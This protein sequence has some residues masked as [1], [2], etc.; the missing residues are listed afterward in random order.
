MELTRNALITGA[1]TGIGRVTAIE[2]SKQ[3]YRLFLAGRSLQRTQAVMEEIRAITGRQDAVHFLPLQLD[4]LASVKA[5][6]QPQPQRCA[7]I[8]G[9]KTRQH[10]FQPATGRCLVRFRCV[11]LCLAPRRGCY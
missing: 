1:N 11:L 7:G 8:R 5:A 4:D 9:L 6:K 3:G 2:L 10:S